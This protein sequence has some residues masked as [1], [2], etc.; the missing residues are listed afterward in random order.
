[1][2]G[3]VLFHAANVA[4]TSRVPCSLEHN[5]SATLA[6]MDWIQRLKPAKWMKY[7]RY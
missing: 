4:R 2:F 6:Q 5:D 7:Q 1:M 3:I